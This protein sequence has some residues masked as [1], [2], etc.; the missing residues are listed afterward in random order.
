M[1]ALNQ[2]TVYKS[3]TKDPYI[4][5]KVSGRNQDKVWQELKDVCL[6]LRALRPEICA[7]VSLQMRLSPTHVQADCVF[8]QPRQAPS[9]CTSMWY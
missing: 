2:A 3:G 7:L 1:V 4:F 9:K 5:L 6:L 8:L